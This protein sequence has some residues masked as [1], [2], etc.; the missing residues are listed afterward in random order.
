MTENEIRERTSRAPLAQLRDVDERAWKVLMATGTTRDPEHVTVVQAIAAH[1]MGAHDLAA[2]I[3][4]TGFWP[5]SAAVLSEWPDHTRPPIMPPPCDHPLEDF[6][7]VEDGYQRQWHTK[8]DDERKV[9]TGV[10][11]GTSDWTD[12]G[13]G[14][15]Y[16]QCGI[17]L[18][19]REVPDDYE[20]DWN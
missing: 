14:H 18:A 16:L 5:L 3:Y 9:L 17:C 4:D 6:Q 10:Y 7:L 1:L 15:V 13:D 11:G 8:I 20:I 12:D 2:L 19:T